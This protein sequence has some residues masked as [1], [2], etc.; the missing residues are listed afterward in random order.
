[1]ISADSAVVSAITGS[2]ATLRCVATGEPDPLQTWTRDSAAVSGS[3][4]Q[5]SAGGSVLTVN[6]V[7]EEDGGMY[8]CHASNSAGMDVAM[9]TLDVQSKNNAV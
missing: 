4:F 7:A 8:T 9:V 2:T 5:I 6:P 1:M 3:R